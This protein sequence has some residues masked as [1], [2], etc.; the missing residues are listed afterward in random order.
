MKDPLKPE[1]S[2]LCKLASIAVHA[3]EMTSETGHPFDRLAFRS[4]LEDTE[5]QEWLKSMGPFV[6]VKRQTG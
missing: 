2:L 6:P 5:V 1:L 3:D 4:A